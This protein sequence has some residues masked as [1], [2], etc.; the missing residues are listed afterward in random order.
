MRGINHLL[1]KKT[2]KNMK[3]TI[4][5]NKHKYKYLVHFYL[6]QLPHAQYKLTNQLLPKKIGVSTETF[7]KWQYIQVDSKATIP[8][9]KLAIIAKFFNLRMEQMFNYQIPELNFSDL[10]EVSIKNKD[11]NL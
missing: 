5:N 10:E 6:N 9:D 1:P 7:R 4:P 11:Q 8:A 3:K 2:K